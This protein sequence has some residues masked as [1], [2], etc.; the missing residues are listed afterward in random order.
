MSA[1]GSEQRWI[2]SFDV[3]I[4]FP[5]VSSAGRF[6]HIVH[7][8]S[9]ISGSTLFSDESCNAHVSGPHLQM[10]MLTLNITL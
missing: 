1:S 8:F 7:S 3:E 9:R 6:V 10:S 2:S 5:S 4:Q